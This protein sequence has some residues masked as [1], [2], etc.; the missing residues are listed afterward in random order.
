[1]IK[2][3]QKESGKWNYFRVVKKFTFLPIRIHQA[4]SQTTWWSWMSTTFIYQ[5]WV[6]D[7]NGLIPYLKWYFNG[8]YWKNIRLS[9]IDEYK[10]FIKS[11][12]C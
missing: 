6:M 3:L 4:T 9:N 12:I 10:D 5:G 7:T 8:G 1:M 11:K 2:K